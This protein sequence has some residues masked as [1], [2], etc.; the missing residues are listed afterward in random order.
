M[1]HLHKQQTKK[2]CEYNF[3]KYCTERKAKQ[4]KLI[5]YINLNVH[6]FP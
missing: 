1:I 5:L 4:V 6:H 2:Y 3:Y